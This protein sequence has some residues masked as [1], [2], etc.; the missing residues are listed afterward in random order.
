MLVRVTG[1]GTSFRLSAYYDG[2]E[3]K[4][5]GS[6]TIRV[7]MKT[8]L[9][10]GWNPEDLFAVFR[11]ETGKLVAVRVS[12]DPA[13]GTL[14]FDAPEL[15]DFRLVCFHWDGTDYESAEFLA[16]LEAHMH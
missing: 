13:T 11:D 2:I 9:D 3:L 6:G 14:V 12:Y 5:L 15:G 1:S 7:S 16:A 10:A 8:Q 4:Q